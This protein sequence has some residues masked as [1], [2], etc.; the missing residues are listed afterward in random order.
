MTIYQ[1]VPITINKYHLRSSS[2][3]PLNTLVTNKAIKKNKK[4]KRELTSLNKPV[5]N[6][7]KLFIIF[8]HLFSHLDRIKSQS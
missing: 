3:H 2:F 8:Y 1:K 4:T 5:T 7:N 6:N